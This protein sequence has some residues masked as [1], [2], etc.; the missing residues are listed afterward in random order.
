MHINTSDAPHDVSPMSSPALSRVNSRHSA[1]SSVDESPE[2]SPIFSP[3][4]ANRGGGSNAP[5]SDTATTP[6]LDHSCTFDADDWFGRFRED[7]DVSD[8]C[9]DRGTL[10]AAGEVP[11]YDAHGNMRHFRTFF[12]GLD[13]IGDRQL[14]IFIRHFYCGVSPRSGLRFYSKSPNSL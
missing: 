6:S 2:A 7:L 3:T 10:A 11:L 14:I 5:L 13:A 12:T 8:D 4:Y 1:V 9:P